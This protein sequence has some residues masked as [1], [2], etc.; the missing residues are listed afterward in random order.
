MELTPKHTL[1]AGYLG[2]MTQAITIN[3]TPLLFITFEKTY[4]ISL[5]K[6]SLLIALSFITQLSADAFEARFASRL[7]TR[8]SAV[9]AH[10]FAAVGML[11]F[12]FLPDV[13]PNAYIGLAIATVITAIGGGMI[14]VLISPIVEACPTNEKSTAMSFLHSFYCWGAVATVLLSTIFFKTV[15][16]EHWKLLYCLWAIVP[17][18]GAIAFSLVPIYKLEAD[19]KA[20]K[21]RSKG[22]SLITSAIFWVFF[23]IMFCSGASEMAMMQWA[24]SFAESALGIDKALG[25]LMGPCSF[26]IFMGI[27]RVLYAAL[28]HKIRL[29]SFITLSAAL[30][31]LSYLVTALSP[32]PILSLLSC[33]LC[34]FSVGIMWPG[35]YSLA[36]KNITFGGTQMFALL[37][38]AGDL[39]CTVGPT[40][41]GWIAELFGNDLKISFILSAIFPTMILALMPFVIGY[42]K[43][44]KASK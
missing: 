27:A 4:N 34:G 42:A 10:I 37:A 33:A 7:D 39:G 24:S 17:I 22:T 19:T 15:G 6:I 12:A 3:F 43:K 38:L 14:E 21:E 31:A 32:L 11:S 16:I 18:I 30:C 29:T 2:Y 28:G 40:A 35:T 5:G 25:D 9:A 44:I 20:G 36:T 23:L 26:A 13:L 1:C 8:R 41:A